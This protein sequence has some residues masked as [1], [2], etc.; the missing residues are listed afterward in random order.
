[1]AEKPVEPGPNATPETQ[2]EPQANGGG[3][4]SREDYS[5]AAQRSKDRT[6]GAENPD[7][8]LREPER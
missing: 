3:T 4:Y 7:K 8:D 6:T 1:M 5:R 2:G